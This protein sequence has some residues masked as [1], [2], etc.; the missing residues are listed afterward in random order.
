MPQ[1]IAGMTN[2]KR[3]RERRT[4][5]NVTQGEVAKLLPCGRSS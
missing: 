3:F 2:R 5:F 4:E 1:P